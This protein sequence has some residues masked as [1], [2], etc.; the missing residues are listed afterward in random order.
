MSP[1]LGIIASSKLSAVGDYESIATTLLT[2]T[3]SSVTFSSI[4]ATFDHLQVRFLAQTNRGTYGRDVVRLEINSFAVGNYAS[5]FLSGDGSTV[6]AGGETTA[7]NV[8]ALA[9]VAGTTTAGADF[10]GASI[11]DI[12]DYKNTNKNKTI[13]TLGGV[14]LNGTVGGAGGEVVLL[15]GLLI[16]TNAITS[17]TFKPNVGTLFSADS[18]FALYGCK[19]A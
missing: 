1:I 3:A 6:S 5:H 12:L 4:P 15:S 2:G 10:F 11:V 18:H 13:R 16:S 17:L 8:F 19:S 14:D 9:G 7:N